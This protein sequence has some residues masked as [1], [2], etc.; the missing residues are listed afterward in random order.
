MKENKNYLL[1]WFLLGVGYQLQVIASLS[2]SEAVVLIVA[3]FLVF[4]EF[5][6]MRRS[7]VVVY[8]YW[9]LALIVGCA[10]SCVANNCSSM[11]VVRGSATVCLIS[12][13]IVVLH[14]LIRCSPNGLRF[15]FLGVCVCLVINTFYFR[16]FGDVVMYGDD[17]D[18]IMGGALYWIHRINY[19]TLLPVRGWYLN[20]PWGI[21]SMLALGVAAFS[22]F[23]SVSGRSSAL[24][25]LAGALLIAIGRKRRESIMKISRFLV[26]YLAVAVLLVPVVYWGYKT[27]CM[28][29]VLGPEARAKFER[30]TRGGGG[31]I[32]LLI[33]GRAQSFA[34]LFSCVERPIVGWGP[35][36][37]DYNG[38]NARFI[39]R[40]GSDDDIRDLEYRNSLRLKYGFHRSGLISTHSTVVQFWV[41]FGLLGLLFVGYITWCVIRFVKMDLAVIPRWYGW[42]A[43]MLP[44]FFWDLFFSPYS[45]RLLYSLL[46]VACLYARAVRKGR[47]MLPAY[48]FAEDPRI[49]A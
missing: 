37:L 24:I 5:P 18:S 15:L 42:I 34:G 20:V 45:D 4:N 6:H 44:S 48:M 19:F 25:S 43:L 17:L 40:Y 11:Q 38:N 31:V 3:P 35:W 8:F 47:V 23:A 28:Q 49:R 29:G 21:S 39:Y 12:A 1:L 7:G 22:A 46:I 30:Q 27:L 13:F 2:I 10:I 32:G 26:L 41:W 14:R 16:R 33:T 36:A 9:S